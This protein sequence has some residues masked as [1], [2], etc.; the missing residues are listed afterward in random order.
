MRCIH[1]FFPS[2]HFV[3]SIFILNISCE[4]K[5]NNFFCIVLFNLILTEHFSFLFLSFCFTIEL[6]SSWESLLHWSENES[7]VKQSLEEMAALVSKLNKIGTSN[8]NL[9]TEA[10]IQLA[11]QETEVSF[12]ICEYRQFCENQK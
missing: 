12:W 6:L 9:D 1:S 4:N 8:P 5:I 2:L 10:A 3:I 11:I 7:F